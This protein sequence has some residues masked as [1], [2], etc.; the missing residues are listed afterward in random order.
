MQHQLALA[1]EKERSASEIA[2]ELKSKYKAL[3]IQYHTVKEEKTKLESSLEDET[4]RNKELKD[5]WN[6]FA[7][8]MLHD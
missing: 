7:L 1:S 8:Y 3:N 6:R 5:T 2:T 4:N